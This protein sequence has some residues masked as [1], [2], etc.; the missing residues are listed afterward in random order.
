MRKVYALCLAVALTL[1]CLLIETSVAYA[2]PS[3]PEFT[4]NDNTV[5]IKNQPF[6]PYHDDTEN[7]TIDLYYQIQTKYHDSDEWVSVERFWV[8]DSTSLYQKRPYQQQD[9]S[10]QYT[11]LK[12]VSNE[13]R[14]DFQVR[15]LIGYVSASGGHVFDF[16]E[17]M[18]TYSFTGEYGEWSSTQTIGT[19]DTTQSNVPTIIPTPR[20]TM[21]PT[22]TPKTTLNPQYTQTSQPLDIPW[23]TAAIVGLMAAVAI[24]AVGMVVMY[25]K[26]SKGKKQ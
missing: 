6:T 7:Q 8:K 22:Q 23:E 12:F 18:T 2:K 14:D 13:G 16:H 1:S 24:L 9:D 19:T 10:A 17:E 15:A 20:A 5:T 4:I 3:V 21:P 26:L 25:H 11:S